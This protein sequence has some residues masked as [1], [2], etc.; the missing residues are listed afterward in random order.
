MLQRWLCPPACLRAECFSKDIDAT[1]RNPPKHKFYADE[2]AQSI[3]DASMRNVMQIEPGTPA[4]DTGR[5]LNFDRIMYQGPISKGQVA[6]EVSY[7]EEVIELPDLVQIGEPFYEDFRIPVM[8]INEIVAEKLR[9]LCQRSRATDLSDLAMIFRD[10]AAALSD[11]D[12]LRIA[13]EKFTLVKDGDRA[14][15]IERNVSH[16]ATEY[17]NTVSNVAPDAPDYTTASETVLAR[18]RGVS[19]A[20]SR[21]VLPTPVSVSAR[22]SSPNGGAFRREIRR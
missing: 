16:I 7:R 22:S 4:T 12:I 13:V 5:S 11:P 2:M 19:A 17:A 6:L 1:R 15:R 20:R 9:T 21:H 18:I 8:A 14:A 10:Q 3:R